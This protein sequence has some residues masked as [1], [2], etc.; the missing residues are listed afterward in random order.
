MKMAEE[1]MQKQAIPKKGVE[2]P[3]IGVD[4]LK[5]GVEFPKIGVEHA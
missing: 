4:F 3:K 2:F 5:I 1:D